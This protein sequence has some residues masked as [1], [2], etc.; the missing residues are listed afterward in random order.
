M[1]RDK[2]MHLVFK[3]IQNEYNLNQIN[4]LAIKLIHTNNIQSYE[5]NYKFKS[6]NSN[7]LLTILSLHDKLYSLHGKLYT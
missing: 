5:Y 7:H 6:H 4:Q 1:L 3:Y 2:F